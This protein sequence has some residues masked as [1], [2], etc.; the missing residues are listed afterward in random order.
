MISNLTSIV[1]SI[2]GN[3][4]EEMAKKVYNYENKLGDIERKLEK[5][6][7][8]SSQAMDEIRSLF[9]YNLKD[10]DYREIEEKLN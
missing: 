7:I 4:A 1:A 8:D 2:I 10:E 5:G 6:V 9:R 3:R